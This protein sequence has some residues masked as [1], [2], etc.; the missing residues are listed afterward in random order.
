MARLRDMRNI[1]S[2]LNVPY[3]RK[4]Y[5]L[6][7]AE[8]V[9]ESRYGFDSAWIVGR[10][11]TGFDSIFKPEVF[12][13]FV[14]ILSP[15]ILLDSCSLSGCFTSDVCT[16]S[17][18]LDVEFTDTT[19]GSPTNWL[20]DFGD[21]EFSDEENPTH[22]YAASGSYSVSLTSWEAGTNTPITVASFTTETKTGTDTSDNY[23]APVPPPVDI[24]HTAFTRF[25][26]DSWTNDPAGNTEYNVF[27]TADGKR[28]TY[29]AGRITRNY[30]FAAYPTAS[31]VIIL[32]ARHQFSLENRESN[33][34]SSGGGARGNT[35]GQSLEPI[36][37]LTSMGG[38]LWSTT[39]TDLNNHDELSAVP[40]NGNETGWAIAG[41][42]VRA[43]T[44]VADSRDTC[45]AADFIVVS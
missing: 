3:S 24:M 22:T 44:F 4:H 1:M 39:V 40:S 2:V 16:G 12:A 21:G 7:D 36:F 14:D 6:P 9:V 35:A 17:A 10:K 33:F 8:L 41:W 43:H 18:P 20:W 45:F 5:R 27:R 34:V 15:V 31:N 42:E 19:S 25:D 28:F 13:L 37:N 26:A 11:I 29:R 30:D 32:S 23:S 38:G